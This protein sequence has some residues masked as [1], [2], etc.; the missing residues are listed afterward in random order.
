VRPC[1]DRHERSPWSDAE[2]LA[3][4]IA[5]FGPTSKTGHGRSAAFPFTRLRADGV[6]TLD[7]KVPMGII[8]P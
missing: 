2:K 7:R 5:E 4:L 6:W 8:T 3:D 1:R